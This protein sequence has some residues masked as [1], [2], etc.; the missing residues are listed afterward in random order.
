VKEA[1][2]QIDEWIASIGKVDGQTAITT[3]T[4]LLEGDDPVAYKKLVEGLPPSVQTYLESIRKGG[5]SPE[6]W[7]ALLAKIPKTTQTELLFKWAEAQAALERARAYLDEM[8]RRYAQIPVRISI[9]KPGADGDNNNNGTPDLIEAQSIKAQSFGDTTVN[10]YAR[11]TLAANRF[12]KAAKSNALIMDPAVLGRMLDRVNIPEKYK[13][14]VPV[15]FDP[16]LGT[17]TADYSE[18]E[19]EIDRR[20][21][22]LDDIQAGKRKKSTAVADAQKAVDEIEKG[23]KPK[24]AAEIAR[25]DQDLAAAKKRLAD[26]KKSGSAGD[27]KA[28]KRDL[29]QAKEWL[30]TAKRTEAIHQRRITLLEAEKARLEAVKEAADQVAASVNALDIGDAYKAIN[31]QQQA[32]KDNAKTLTDELARIDEQLGSNKSGLMKTLS[33]A[34]QGRAEAWNDQLRAYWDAKVK[35]AEAALASAERDAEDAREKARRAKE[36]ADADAGLVNGQ[37]QTLRQQLEGQIKQT[38]DFTAKL[39]ALQQAGVSKEAIQSIIDQGVETGSALADQLL[40]DPELARFY[41][42]AQSDLKKFTEDW[43]LDLIEPTYK[44]MYKGVSQAL[45]QAYLDYE[46]WLD[47]RT[48]KAKTGQKIKKYGDASTGQPIIVNFN[49]PVNDPDAAARAI[50]KQLASLEARSAGMVTV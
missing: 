41:S 46:V 40:A 17:W 14:R 19:R 23:P 33:D 2:Q 29:A 38:K 42:T 12:G 7:A 27:E 48:G 18:I 37:P 10:A 22:R 3:L 8:K 21:K 50:R 24:T 49:A 35:E 15:K 31:D 44:A 6:E 47:Q 5:V 34:Q 45:Q 4:A 30:D 16:A 39:T 36:K 28:A 11:A 20:Q 13:L 32:A 9:Q 25:R 26:A 1:Q 43:A